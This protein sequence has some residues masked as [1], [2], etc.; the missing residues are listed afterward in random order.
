VYFEMKNKPHREVRA[1][2]AP[3]L[4]PL[5]LLRSKEAVAVMLDLV[6]PAWPV[7]E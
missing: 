6:Q 5:A 7:G 2:S 3:D 4:K 1:A